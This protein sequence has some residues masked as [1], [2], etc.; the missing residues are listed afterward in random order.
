[1][2]GIYPYLSPNCKKDGIDVTS[3][4]RSQVPLEIWLPD[5]F[6]Y[7]VM[8]VNQIKEMIKIYPNGS[9]FWSRHLIVSFPEPQM[10]FKQYPLDRQNFS[11]VLQSFAHDSTTLSMSFVSNAA[12]AL[13]T[14][15][16]YKTPLIYLN[17]LWIYQSY[18]GFIINKASPSP[19]N[20]SRKFSTAYINLAF[21]RQKMGI[22][23]RLALPVTVFVVIVGFSFWTSLDMRVDVTLQMILVISALYLVISQVI[24]FV[25]YFTIMDNFITLVFIAL[26]LQIAVHF[27]T[28]TIEKTTEA[29]PFNAVFNLFMDFM[30]R[31]V[32]IP[33]SMLVFIMFFDMYEPTIL[34]G[35]ITITVVTV[36]VNIFKMG[37]I[38]GV[39]ENAIYRLRE[40]FS[41]YDKEE[42]E[43]KKR[44][45]VPTD[46]ELFVLRQTKNFYRDESDNSAPVY[47][48]TPSVSTKANFS[49]NFPDFSVITEQLRKYF[50]GT[51]RRELTDTEDVL[52]FD[53]DNQ[54]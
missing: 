17:Q 24:P 10:N 54:M 6:F 19:A 30:F 26:S 37:K 44:L 28:L 11:I 9:M 21:Q 36:V 29:H 53:N 34:A 38:C 42:D 2:P 8:D 41:I 52:T 35:M 45:L 12:V 51:N 4:V 22:V 39:F 5:I 50:V 43:F 48:R 25:G 18:S 16:Q 14:N 7:S 13:L 33:L 15:P 27:L 1:M 23:L 40:K 47:Q 3:Y 32:W 49:M 20:P 31:L 46:F